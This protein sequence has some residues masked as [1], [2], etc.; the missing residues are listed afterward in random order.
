[1]SANAW[2]IV[3]ALCTLTGLV[4]TGI[5][6]RRDGTQE[7]ISLLQVSA[8]FELPPGCFQGSALATMLAQC[9]PQRKN[10]NISHP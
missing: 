5:G 8:G 7:N 9:N 3:G 2:H 1:M 6:D 4:T 10:Y